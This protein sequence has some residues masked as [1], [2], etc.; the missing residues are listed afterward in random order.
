M[1]SPPCF[2]PPPAGSSAVPTAAPTTPAPRRLEDSQQ[3][4]EP[5]SEAGV[6]HWRSEALLRSAGCAAGAE[7]EGVL[8]WGDVRGGAEGRR[9]GAHLGG[10]EES[11][12]RRRSRGWDGRR[13]GRSRRSR[14]KRS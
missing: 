5:S 6:K 11:D 14:S 4:P 1:L 2:P 7:A 10:Q 3:A 12:S 13:T 9:G 8:H